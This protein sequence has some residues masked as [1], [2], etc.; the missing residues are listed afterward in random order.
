MKKKA[1]LV[2]FEGGDK[3][4]KSTQIALL[5]KALKKRRRLVKICREPGGTALG[6]KI[7]Q[8]LLHKKHP[9]SPLIE[10][11]L[12]GFGGPVECNR[13]DQSRLEHG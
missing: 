2:T 4:G 5:A 3:C 11:Q 13:R 12:S 6:E 8:I 7:R 10:F 9:L 1:L